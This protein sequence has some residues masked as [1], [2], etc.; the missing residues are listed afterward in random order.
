MLMWKPS[1]LSSERRSG[2]RKKKYYINNYNNKQIAYVL[3]ALLVS[4]VILTLFILSV[5]SLTANATAI[6]DNNSVK[7]TKQESF[8]DS[9]GRLNIIGV[10]DNNGKIPSS[11]Y[12]TQLGKRVFNQ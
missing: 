12:I 1:L 6:V 8:R 10:V 3:V 2:K 11:K 9:N 7:M 5:L 4:F